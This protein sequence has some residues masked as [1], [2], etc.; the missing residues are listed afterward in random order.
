MQSTFLRCRL[1]ETM[2]TKPSQ[3]VLRP[4]REGLRVPLPGASRQYLPAG[5]KLVTLSR[6]WLR[7]I[8]R[9]DV[10]RATAEAKPVLDGP[11][12]KPSEKA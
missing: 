3:V 4:S 12:V 8:S 9:G 1:P 10:V 11:R 5:G 6:Y 7:A 2:P